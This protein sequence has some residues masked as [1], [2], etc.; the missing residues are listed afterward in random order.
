[1]PQSGRSCRRQLHEKITE[2]PS[3]KADIVGV[4]LPREMSKP[5]YIRQITPLNFIYFVPQRRPLHEVAQF[6]GHFSYFLVMLQRFRSE[7]HR[8]GIDHQI[9]DHIDC[10]RGIPIG[11]DGGMRLEN[12]IGIGKCPMAELVGNDDQRHFHIFDPLGQLDAPSQ[13]SVVARL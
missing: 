3:I 2:P 1:M 11:F 12:I 5:R 7:L 10:R 6:R 13:S 4:A 9:E 8:N